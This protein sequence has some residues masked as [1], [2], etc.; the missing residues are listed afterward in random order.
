MRFHHVMA[1][2]LASAAAFW[3][4]PA[5]AGAL[6]ISPLRLE[7]SSQ[8]TATS[9][10]VRNG[11]TAATLVQAEA[12]LWS[13]DGGE[14][15]LEPANDV[16]ISPPVFTIPADG[17]QLVRIALRRDADASRE[18]SYRLILQEVP[19]EASPDFTGL[20]VALRLSVPIFVAPTSG[21]A[22]PKLEFSATLNADGA[23]VLRADNNGTAHGRVLS[24]S[25][26]P[27][28]GHGPVLQDSVASYVLPGQYRTWT[29]KNNETIR[30]DSA[31]NA[32]RYRLKATTERGEVVTEL[33]VTR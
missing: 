33:S 19:A 1:S 16:I 15:K 4:P 6:S 18:L 25:L 7:L 27:A 10:T 28:S 24:F 30:D 31:A 20:R 2:V 22:E 29:I 32:D 21:R 11:N 5:S 17:S 12:F 13:Q 14:D 23:L 26:T 3:L 9:L 8:A